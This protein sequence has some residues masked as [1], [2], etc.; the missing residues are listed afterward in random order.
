MIVNK[1]TT[2]K[3]YFLFHLTNMLALESFLVNRRE[4]SI[5]TPNIFQEHIIRVFVKDPAKFDIVDKAFT[6]FCNE[7]I[8]AT[9]K[10][11]K[12]FSKRY[13]Q[14]SQYVV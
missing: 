14:D 8:G 5:I 10:K 3:E 7:K 4:V 12:E 1:Q 13:T 11:G 6:R 9:P 2:S